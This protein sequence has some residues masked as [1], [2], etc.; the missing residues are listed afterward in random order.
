MMD[1][2]RSNSRAGSVLSR[3]TLA[4]LYLNGKP[5]GQVY[6]KGWEDSWGLG[7]FHPTPDFSEYAPLYGLW[8][9]LMHADEDTRL[10]REASQE[11]SQAESQLDTIK[12]RLLFPQNEEWVDVAQLT[13]DG[14][15]LEWKEY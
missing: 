1:V 12:A 9:L 2:R 6:V 7:E 4:L 11:L 14:A 15:L 5:V 13:I 10:S 8:S 3:G